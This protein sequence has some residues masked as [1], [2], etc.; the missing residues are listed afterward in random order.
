MSLFVYAVKHKKYMLIK[1]FV[2]LTKYTDLSTITLIK[3]GGA[4]NNV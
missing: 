2:L 3:Y 1:V 4:I